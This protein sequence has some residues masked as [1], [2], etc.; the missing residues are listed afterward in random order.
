M[1]ITI[2]GQIK[3][4]NTGLGKALN[5]LIDAA[6]GASNIGQVNIVDITN[7]F[8]FLL[9]LYRLLTVR[10]DVFYLTPAG[11]LFG[12]LR[13]S[14][15]LWFIQLKN[16][17]VIVHFHNSQYGRTLERYSWLLPIN[18]YLYRNVSAIIILGDKQRNMFAGMNVSENKFIVIRNGIDEALFIDKFTLERKWSQEKLQVAYFSNMIPE[19]GYMRVLDVAK[20]LSHDKRFHFN[21]SGKFFDEDLKERFL[22]EIDSLDNATYFPGVYGED[23]RKFLYSV[24]IFV[25]PSHYAD[26]TLPISMLEAASAGAYLLVSDVG[27]ISEVVN[28]Q[29]AT[30]LT[31]VNQDEIKGEILEVWEERKSL[32]FDIDYYRSF[33]NQAIQEEI[34]QV[35]EKV[36]R[37]R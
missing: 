16:K 23:K 19:K 20:S 12:N 5:D 6:R 10:T 24:H 13:D 11:S 33:E 26:E 34:L 21:F 1:N 4:R 30:L 36:Y 35:F 3:N 28:M 37:L 27:V 15:I 18:A 25:L 9:T 14:V 22:K 17:P 29:V 7:N 8:A 32:T 31:E 2:L